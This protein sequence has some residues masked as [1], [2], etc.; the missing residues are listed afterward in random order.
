MVQINFHPLFKVCYFYN[1]LHL[2]H[3]YAI[4]SCNKSKALILERE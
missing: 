1:M 2:Q 3:T 4:I